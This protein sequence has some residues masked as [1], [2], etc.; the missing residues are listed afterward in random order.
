MTE[1]VENKFTE[2]EL[3]DNAKKKSGM[4]YQLLKFVSPYLPRKR[5]FNWLFPRMEAISTIFS[6]KAVGSKF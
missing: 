3:K 1:K 4:K 2:Q 6:I 5:D